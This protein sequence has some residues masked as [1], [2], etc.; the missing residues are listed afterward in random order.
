MTQAEQAILDQVAPPGV[1][2]DRNWLAASIQARL[3]PDY[4]P[5]VLAGN[6]AQFQ[7]G[8]QGC[9]GNLNGAF[10]GGYTA[11]NK[12]NTGLGLLSN[13]PIVGSIF[14][15]IGGILGF[16]TGIFGKH[17]AAAVAKERGTLCAAVPAQNALYQD[18]DARW[19][20]GRLSKSNALQVV[21]NARGQF[22]AGIKAI[23]AGDRRCNEA[24]GYRH[25]ND[26]QVLVRQ[27]IAYNRTV[28][29]Y[30]VKYAA[31][32]AGVLV[33]GIVAFRKFA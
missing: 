23:D 31:A 24:C 11:V 9:D 33:L 25:A 7:G 12:V 15:A 5:G 10:S 6:V 21:A 4:E 26:A 18:T 16:A 2:L 19:A 3:L 13:I 1:R 22:D 28:T 27:Q 14:G 32:G 29:P 30:W 17:H 20:A 8:T